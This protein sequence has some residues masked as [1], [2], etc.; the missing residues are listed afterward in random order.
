M[1]LLAGNIFFVNPII[2]PPTIRK[3]L[4][5]HHLV[6]KNAWIDR[7]TTVVSIGLEFLNFIKSC[8]SKWR[9]LGNSIWTRE[10]DFVFCHGY[11]LQ[12]W[13]LNVHIYQFQI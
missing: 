13:A 7:G 3:F 9:R 1:Q 11:E 6:S 5:S 10:L 4:N 2:R 12:N 8:C